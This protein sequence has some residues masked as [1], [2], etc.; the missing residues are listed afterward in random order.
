MTP[1]WRTYSTGVHG[2]LEVEVAKKPLDR[3]HVF[4]VCLHRDSKAVAQRVP[5]HRIG[6][7]DGFQR[8][9]QVWQV[10]SK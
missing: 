6:D 1:I 2:H 3:L 7:A 5:A 9:L 4:P 10:S 8:R